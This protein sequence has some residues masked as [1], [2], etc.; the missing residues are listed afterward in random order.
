MLNGSPISREMELKCLTI[1]LKLAR[2]GGSLPAP[3]QYA[4][5]SLD[6]SVG[7]NGTLLT[8]VVALA[9]TVTFPSVAPVGTL[10]V[11]SEA[12]T[13]VNVAAVP[14]PDSGDSE[15]V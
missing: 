5:G 9:L 11:I 1:F 4:P 10:A 15:T 7:R 14:D 3:S 2:L 8:N 12:D 13:T 6:Y